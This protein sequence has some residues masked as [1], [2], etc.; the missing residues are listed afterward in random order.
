MANKI[1]WVED[2]A[3]GLLKPLGR[4]LERAGLEVETV[5]DVETAMSRLG[6]ESYDAF[7]LD[8]ILPVYSGHSGLTI[9]GGLEVANEVRSRERQSPE[10]KKSPIVFLTVMS[11]TEMAD[12]L[13]KLEAKL[14]EKRNLTSEN[15]SDLVQS[16]MSPKTDP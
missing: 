7:L 13:G 6:T 4:M 15:L 2:E 10:G 3:E 16:L 12:D 1:L 8:A 5:P 14:F 11:A 9:L